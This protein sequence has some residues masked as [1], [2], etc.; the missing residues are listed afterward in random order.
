MRDKRVYMYTY[1]EKNKCNLFLPT[2]FFK[3][4][5]LQSKISKHCKHYSGYTYMLEWILANVDLHSFLY[6][7]YS[8]ECRL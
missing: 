4:F 2:S 5:L 3:Q 8:L 1:K 7:K 6:N